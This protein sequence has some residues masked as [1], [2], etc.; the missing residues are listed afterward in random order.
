MHG[1]NTEQTL[2]VVPGLPPISVEGTKFETASK[3]DLVDAYKLYMRTKMVGASN[4]LPPLLDADFAEVREMLRLPEQCAPSTFIEYIT[5][6]SHSGRF[7][8]GFGHVG[9]IQE[10]CDCGMHVQE[11]G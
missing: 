4:A 8:F 2:A 10:A 1:E 9:A 7:L 11:G 5:S 3:N 6:R